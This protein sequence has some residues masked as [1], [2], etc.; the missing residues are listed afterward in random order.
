MYYRD[1]IIMPGKLHIEKDERRERRTAITFAPNNNLKLLQKIRIK[2][3][4]V[5]NTYDLAN[6]S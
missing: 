1:R 6:L 5:D 2:S 4:I 3:Y